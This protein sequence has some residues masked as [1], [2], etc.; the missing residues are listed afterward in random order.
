[1]IRLDSG[2]RKTVIGA[3]DALFAMSSNKSSSSLHDLDDKDSKKGKIFKKLVMHSVKKLKKN[4]K[5]N[6]H[7]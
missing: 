1:M 6:E 7:E 2:K 3:F 4:V 5:G